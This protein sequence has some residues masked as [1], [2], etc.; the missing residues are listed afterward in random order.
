[1]NVGLGSDSTGSVCLACRKPRIWSP[2]LYILGVEVT[3]CNS[4]TLE[5]EAKGLRV[6]SHPQLLREFEDSLG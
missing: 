1:M 2:L 3:L 5:V 4:G 6:Q